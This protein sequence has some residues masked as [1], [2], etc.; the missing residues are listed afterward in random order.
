MR[1]VPDNPR[2]PDPNRIANFEVKSYVM[3]IVSA[4]EEAENPMGWK[5]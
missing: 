4:R 3:R 1:R 2:D 5:N